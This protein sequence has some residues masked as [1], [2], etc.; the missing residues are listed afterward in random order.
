MKGREERCGEWEF[1]GRERDGR[2]GEG[3]GDP[4]DNWP[5]LAVCL[6]FNNLHLFCYFVNFLSLILYSIKAYQ[7]CSIPR[8]LN[9]Y[10]LQGTC[11]IV[12]MA[13]YL[14]IMS[15]IV[16]HEC[17]REQLCAS[18]TLMASMITGPPYYFKVVT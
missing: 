16:A 6:M 9:T 15:R 10:F 7:L 3:K 2:R 1:K 18:V 5:M 14:R 13:C 12:Y 4:L 17:K 11:C 8:K